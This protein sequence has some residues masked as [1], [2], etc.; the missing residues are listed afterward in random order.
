VTLDAAALTDACAGHLAAAQLTPA[1]AA[2]A[3][4]TVYDTYAQ[5]A[6]FGASL[7]TLTGRKA[8]FEAV[9]AAGLAVGM[10]GTPTALGNAVAAYWAPAPAPVPVVGVQSG[11]V[12]GCPGAAS[13]GAALASLLAV[14]NTPAV[15]AAALAG[16][17]HTA[18]LTVTA[19]V[20]PPPGTVLPIA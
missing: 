15:A 12:V 2:A 1:A 8:L 3:F 14:P 17:L 11:T 13:I 4:A 19:T 9:L 18:T 20:T 5:G 10:P 6:T 7:P 16:A